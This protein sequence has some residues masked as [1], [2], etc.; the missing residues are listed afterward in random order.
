MVGLGPAGPEHVTAAADLA[1]RS[2]PVALL[3]TARHPAAAAYAG[4]PGVSSLDDRYEASSTFPEVY[5]AVVEAVVA[6]ALEHDDVVYAVPGSPTV[7]E[8]TV[9][10]LRALAGG[11]DGE[12]DLEVLPAMSFAELAFLRLGVDPVEA[13]VRLVDAQHF[14]IELGAGSGA[15]GGAG[16]LLVAQCWSQAVLSEVKLAFETEP[17]RPVTLLH[18]LG[19][20]DEVVIEVPWAEIDRTIAPDHLTSLYVPTVGTSTGARSWGSRSSCGC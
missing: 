8:H 9:E 13:G 1:I 15:A 17:G 2:A 10:L 6:A 7:A 16:P 14:A 3:R 4:L 19:L 20:D 12:I 18:H 11:D 5:A